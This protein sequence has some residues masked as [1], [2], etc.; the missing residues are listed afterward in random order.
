[1]SLTQGQIYKGTAGS[2]SAI[3]SPFEYI[4]L[5]QSHVVNRSGSPISGSQ[6][7]ETLD[8]WLYPGDITADGSF[9]T[10]DE[11]LNY[12]TWSTDDWQSSSDMKRTFGGASRPEP[13]NGDGLFTRNTLGA[14][15]LQGQ[16]DSNYWSHSFAQGLSAVQNGQFTFMVGSDRDAAPGQTN[17]GLSN[18]LVTKRFKLVAGQTDMSSSASVTLVAYNSGTHPVDWDSQWVLSTDGSQLTYYA[19]TNSSTNFEDLN[20]N[21]NNASTK[22]PKAKIYQGDSS[23]YSP[24]DAPLEILARVGPG[25][26]GSSDILN[27]SQINSQSW[28]TG[29]GSFQFGR[30]G[31]TVNSQFNDP[32]TAITQ[33]LMPQGPFGVIGNTDDVTGDP[34]LAYYK[35]FFIARKTNGHW[36]IEYSIASK[37]YATPKE[38]SG[39]LRLTFQLKDGQTAIDTSSWVEGQATP[40]TV[41]VVPI[42][43]N[44]SDWANNWVL[45]SDATTLTYYSDNSGGVSGLAPLSTESFEF[46]DISQPA[47]PPVAATKGEIYKGDLS[48]HVVIDSPF[49]YLPVWAGFDL[50][51]N[52]YGP[53]TQ[54][55]REWYYSGLDPYLDDDNFYAK[56]SSLSYAAMVGRTVI[57]PRRRWFEP[58]SAMHW[59]NNIDDTKNARML[60]SNW[61]ARRVEG[62]WTFALWSQTENPA[63]I[64][65]PAYTPMLDFYPTR[66]QRMDSQI[67]FKLKPEQTV[68]D[69]STWAS[70]I[71]T[72]S[73][74]D[75]PS[76][77]IQDYQAPEG[78]D[79]SFVANWDESTPIRIRHIEFDS[80]LHSQNLKGNWLV[81]DA[82]TELQFFYESGV[83]DTGLAPMVDVLENFTSTWKE[84]QTI[85]FDPL[86]DSFLGAGTIN[87]T[88]TSSSGLPITFTSSDNSIAE[89]AGSVLT[90][91]ALGTVSITA[92]QAGDETYAAAS[93]AQPLVITKDSQTITFNPLI[94]ALI[95]PSYAG[96]INLTATASSGLPVTFISSD[97]SI[98]EVAGSV[99]TLKTTGTVS[100]TASQAGDVNTF[101]ATDVSQ[102]LLIQLD[103]DGDGIPDSI[104]PD[105]DNDGIAD[106][107]DPYPLLADH[108][109]ING[110]KIIAQSATG[111]FGTNSMKDSVISVE[112]DMYLIVDSVVYQQK[113]NYSHEQIPSN[114]SMVYPCVN[115][116]SEY[117]VINLGSDA[118]N[119]S[120]TNINVTLSGFYAV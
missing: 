61:H 106:G 28:Y 103:S 15:A 41:D 116:I 95:G 6:A 79:G 114:A 57:T 13:N 76:L 118:L 36:L 68:F 75:Y 88:A 63:W 82:G 31:N 99:L 94:D 37:D 84:S 87:L 17:N 119:Y 74:S 56:S 92:S 10:S 90:L 62:S 9:I 104:D 72:P 1:M 4:P 29:Q 49:E 3:S 43:S 115:N 30:Y 47:S 113:V 54:N 33:G 52:S 96:T 60:K 32:F 45:S 22:L 50:N 81:N 5:P 7:S 25:T 64:P 107:A 39:M 19:G 77:E 34:I 93:V 38:N 46:G 20:S 42:G 108:P 24:I 11:W 78:D 8:S 117:E 51:A 71:A 66:M 67:V 18:T 59:L 98:A 48:T 83:A 91:K 53:T 2:Y 110:R 55:L 14:V 73:N 105:D 80:S 70:H 102:S 12:S 40:I 65:H 89:V 112:S 35:D 27:T 85:T 100:I 101:P 21:I 120:D 109:D 58:L 86:S 69:T 111:V 26:N 16:N 97:D 23:S 44:P